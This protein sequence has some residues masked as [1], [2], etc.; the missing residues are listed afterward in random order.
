MPLQPTSDDVRAMLGMPL[1]F[2]GRR[3][4]VMPNP[5]KQ[6]CSACGIT[7]ECR[8]WFFRIAP[9]SKT[10]VWQCTEAKNGNRD[11]KNSKA[12]FEW[13]WWDPLGSDEWKAWLAQVG[14]D[15]RDILAF[16]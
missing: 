4:P 3:L 12:N 8:A 15:A 14:I 9:G 1:S 11:D 10:R 5:D 7:G 13:Y 16:G 6:L 2:K